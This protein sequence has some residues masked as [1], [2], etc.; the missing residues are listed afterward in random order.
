M[1]RIII[2]SQSRVFWRLVFSFSVVFILSLSLLFFL[3]TRNYA[4]LKDSAMQSAREQ[5]AQRQAALNGLVSEMQNVVAHIQRDP[6]FSSQLAAHPSGRAA[7]YEDLLAMNNRMA[8]IPKVNAVWNLGIY[9]LGSEDAL[10]VDQYAYAPFSTKNVEFTYA[11]R[12]QMDGISYADLR[13]RLLT[14]KYIESFWPATRVTDK[15]EDVDIVPFVHILYGG[16]YFQ[17]KG[18]ALFYVDQAAL[19]QLIL[20]GQ[21]ISASHYALLSANGVCLSTSDGAQALTELYL[22]APGQEREISMYG[23]AYALLSSR[24]EVTGLTL[25]YATPLSGILLSAREMRNL[26]LALLLAAV[27]VECLVIGWLSTRLSLPVE[28]IMRSLS[29]RLPERVKN[30]DEYDFI[31]SAVL[32]LLEDNQYLKAYSDKKATE[33]KTVFLET[34]ATGGF[35]SEEALQSAMLHANI[36]LCADAY[37]AASFA[38]SSEEVADE[39]ITYLKSLLAGHEQVLHAEFRAVH[40]GRFDLLLSLSGTRYPATAEYEKKLFLALRDGLGLLSGNAVTR[41]GVGR[42]CYELM[43]IDQSVNEAHEALDRAVDLKQSLVFYDMVPFEEDPYPIEM[44]VKLLNT[45]RFGSVFEL[46]RLI[47]ALRE[48]V[49]L[50]DGANRAKQ[51]YVLRQMANTLYKLKYQISLHDAEIFERMRMVSSMLK[52][53]FAPSALFE[54]ISGTLERIAQG[55]NRERTGDSVSSLVG[56][57]S[58]YI[59]AHYPNPELSVAMI[60]DVFSRNEKYLSR[61]F[62]EHTGQTLV[63]FIEDLRMETALK[64]LENSTLSIQA[65]ALSVGYQNSN[66]FFKAFKRRYGVTPSAYRTQS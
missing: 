18:C 30:Q 48:E 1:N 12:L 57:V 9:L 32:S 49:I 42:L 44:E 37:I 15:G 36:D 24:S 51:E 43:R 45:A 5:L 33:L 35:H 58:A 21:E 7:S 22:R 53:E 20:P 4:R 31:Q 56:E 10:I 54:L 13:E 63:S 28:K 16:M 61:V 50:E 65:I 2:P 59:H 62:R 11:Q 64:L 14:A 52:T 40:N 34:L 47:E 19:A 25:V 66:T 26:F 39:Q 8:S 3:F 6:V 29:A 17:P 60:G 55:E 27:L 41:I 23:E 38:P 46:R